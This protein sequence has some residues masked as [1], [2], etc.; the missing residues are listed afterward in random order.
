MG[1]FLFLSL[2]ILIV[3]GLYWFA[4]ASPQTLLA[5]GRRLGGLALLAVA[6]V[7]ALRGMW[8][9]AL[10]VAAFAF[11]VLRSGTP[12]GF[13]LGTG[14]RKSAGTYSSVRSR[15]FDMRLDHDSG[16]MDGRVVEGEFKD[17][18]LSELTMGE[19][20]ELRAYVAGDEESTALLETYLDQR[21]PGWRDGQQ[22]E[23]ESKRSA[24]SGEPMSVEEARDILGVAPNATAAEIRSA[25]RARMKR[26]HPD[27]GGSTY[28]ASKLNQA[29]EVLLKAAGAKR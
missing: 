8:I 2:L 21:F 24:T 13:G 5:V 16:D 3:A 29:R 1:V 23:G 12:A 10:P 7:L 17:R 27:Q 9:A 4:Y 26:A 11:S 20:L 6:A 14:R 18:L 25:H 22:E 19:L 28:F 15:F